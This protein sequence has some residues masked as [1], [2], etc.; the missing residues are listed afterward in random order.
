MQARFIGCPEQ[1]RRHRSLGVTLIEL[2][3]TLSIAAI[4]LT[5]AVPAFQAFIRTTHARTVATDLAAAFSLARS[6]AIKRGWPVTVCKSGNIQ[7][8]ALACSTAASWQDGWVVF[9]DTDQDGVVDTG[10]TPLR[11]GKPATSRIAISAGSNYSDYVTYFPTGYSLGNGG[12]A[13]GTLAICMEGTQRSL[14]INTTGRLRIDTG[15]C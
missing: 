7:A 1:N 9:V 3:V 5:L 15:T 6:E 4:M 13:D 12:L 8:S 11:V 2:M 14:V 10:D